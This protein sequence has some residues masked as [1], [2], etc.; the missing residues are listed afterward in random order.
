MRD[1]VSVKPFWKSKTLWLNAAVVVDAGASFV[2]GHP[3]LLA[4]TGLSP[5]TQ[6]LVVAVANAIVRFKTTQAIS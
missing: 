2:T 5:A 6:A 3:S 4:S 1:E